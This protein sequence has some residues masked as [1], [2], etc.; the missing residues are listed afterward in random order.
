MTLGNEQIAE[1]ASTT[2]EAFY[3]TDAYTDH[4]IRF[5]SEHHADGAAKPFF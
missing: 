2:N 4:A 5:L 1:P 3:T